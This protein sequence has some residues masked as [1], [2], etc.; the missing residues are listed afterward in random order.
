MRSPCWLLIL[1]LLLPCTLGAQSFTGPVVSVEEGDVLQILRDTSIVMVQLHGI[2]T[3][4]LGQPYG[5]E[6][7][8]YVGHR[9]LHDTVTVIVKERKGPDSLSGIVKTSDG[10]SLN[11][12]LLQQGLAW[13][14]NQEAPEAAHLQA[15]ER[16][17]QEAK[18]RIWS[19]YH[20]IAPW[21]WRAGRRGSS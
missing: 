4:E 20:P 21:K 17:A 3:P 8:H 10:T 1:F 9:V 16:K 14:H 7:S 2:D 11:A 12:T 19:Q 6:A 15:L 5:R 13:W 18:R